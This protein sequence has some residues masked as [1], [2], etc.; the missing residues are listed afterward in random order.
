MREFIDNY[1]LKDLLFKCDDI[2]FVFDHPF[3]SIGYIL[4]IPLGFWAMITLLT[5]I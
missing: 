5:L 1:I 2:D 3:L 4:I